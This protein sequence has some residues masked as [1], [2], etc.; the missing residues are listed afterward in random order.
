MLWTNA[1]KL[2]LYISGLLLVVAMLFERFPV[3]ILGLTGFQILFTMATSLFFCF[4]ALRPETNTIKFPKAPFL[5]LYLLYLGLK[6]LFSPE[7]SFIMSVV[8]HFTAIASVII[9]FNVCWR[10]GWKT[11]LGI[12]RFAGILFI[13][14]S[15]LFYFAPQLMD[16]V[17]LRVS[18]DWLGGIRVLRLTG[19]AN[20]PNFTAWIL[21]L[22][23]F[24]LIAGSRESAGLNR[25][26]YL[27]LAG[28]SL[29]SIVLT[30]SRG[31]IVS[32]VLAGLVFVFTAKPTSSRIS[33]AIIFLSALMG[34]IV[35]AGF[36]YLNQT[37]QVSS[38]EPISNSSS[39]VGQLQD[40]LSPQ[41][42]EN[43]A[44]LT[45]WP[46]GL[47]Q[48]AKNPVFGVNYPVLVD[49]KGKGFPDAYLHNTWL[50]ILVATGVFG[51]GLVAS[52]IFQSLATTRK[53][54]I[55]IRQAAVSMLIVSIVSAAFLSATTT[56]MLWL[57]ILF[58]YFSE[59]GGI[60]SETGRN[61]KTGLH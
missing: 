17:N 12:F 58:P 43:E 14:G 39:L 8:S 23:T 18:Y 33:K 22:L 27:I 42:L 47:K 21:G 5:Y 32:V 26:L 10:L 51:A 7:P 15:Y 60:S 25:L 20:D 28:V 1:N 24:M 46:L 50:D 31:G 48:L 13:L 16:V 40:R 56:T 2:L 54:P 52:L 61:I 6:L 30:W 4:L 36:V 38:I 11:F 44:R 41:R 57:S 29:V 49:L 3:K 37:S 55:V 53:L 9:L 34:I 45:L 19:I 35:T 59:Q